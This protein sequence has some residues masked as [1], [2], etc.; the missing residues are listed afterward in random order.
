LQYNADLFAKALQFQRTD[1]GT[2]EEDRPR[3]WVIKAQDQAEQGRLTDTTGAD[4]RHGLARIYREAQMS[5]HRAICTIGEAYVTKFDGTT[6]P[7]QLHGSR[8]VSNIL[9]LIKDLENPLCPGDRPA[10]RP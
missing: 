9:R 3:C 6:D 4:N 7:L 8:H 10:D 1:I 2:I 5:K